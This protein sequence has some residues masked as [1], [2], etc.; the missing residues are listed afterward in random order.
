[1]FPVSPESILSLHHANAR[2]LREYRSLSIAAPLAAATTALVAATRT[3]IDA[4]TS[5]AQNATIVNSNA[6]PCCA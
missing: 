2:D 4:L 6:A 1:M 5:K 3:Q